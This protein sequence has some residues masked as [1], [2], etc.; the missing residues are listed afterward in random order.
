MRCTRHTGPHSRRSRTLNKATAEGF[1]ELRKA[2]AEAEDKPEVEPIEIAAEIERSEPA[3]AVFD[4]ADD[5]VTA[6]RKL[7]AIKALAAE[8][9]EDEPRPRRHANMRLAKEWTRRP[10]ARSRRLIRGLHRMETV[11]A[12]QTDRDRNR[13]ED[14]PSAPTS[15]DN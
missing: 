11:T 6:T 15:A 13:C 1:T 10:S 4:S 9:D 8:D 12:G 7:Q 3:D 5:F 2:V 14:Q